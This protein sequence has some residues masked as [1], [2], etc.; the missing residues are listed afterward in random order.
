MSLPNPPQLADP[1]RGAGS[2]RQTRAATGTAALAAVPGRSRT[3]LLT[4]PD[5]PA[6]TTDW[7]AVRASPRPGCPGT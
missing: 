2:L 4:E 5:S 7:P 3:L 6:S 1:A